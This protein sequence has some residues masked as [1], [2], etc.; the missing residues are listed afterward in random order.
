MVILVV[1]ISPPFADLVSCKATFV[2]PAQNPANAAP[3]P[4]PKSKIHISSNETIVLLKAI[5]FTT[6]TEHVS[7]VGICAA[8]LKVARYVIFQ[9]SA[10]S[11][12]RT[13]VSSI[14]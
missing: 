6:L 11:W 14:C 9:M 12:T 4:K 10:L 13:R 3:V 8:G 1:S 7:G 5:L 2:Y